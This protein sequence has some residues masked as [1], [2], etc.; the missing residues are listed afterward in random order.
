[1]PAI[2]KGNQKAIYALCASFLVALLAIFGLGQNLNTILKTWLLVVATSIFLFAAI[3]LL[4]LRK[5]GHFARGMLTRSVIIKLICYGIIIYLL[6]LFLGFN[7]G[8]FIT[9]TQNFFANFLPTLILTIVIELLRYIIV[10]PINKTKPAVVI[11]TTLTCITYLFINLANSVPQTAEQLF[12]FTSTIFLPIL[13]RESLSSFIVYRVGLLPNLVYRLSILLYP[14]LIPIVP[15]LGDYLY[16]VTNL[17]LPF[18]IMLSVNKY[19]GVEY[20]NGHGK[21]PSYIAI[22]IPILVTA[23]ILTVLTAGIFRH[24]LIAIAS[25]SM[26]PTFARGD[27]VL[28]EKLDASEIKIGDILVFRKD[29]R[30]VTHRAIS[31]ELREGEYYFTTQGDAND[32]PDAVEV[33]GREVIGRVDLVGKLIGYPTVWLKEIFNKGK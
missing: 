32:D 22:I 9:S 23:I 12:I 33:N 17:I 16:A 1:M 8:Y 13:A 2:T 30:I 18:T 25:N 24:Q 28:I 5:D 11:F 31:M 19:S 29:S 7:R 6:G 21:R 26:F 3:H 15:N 10:A 20:E 14:Y 27:A 4:G